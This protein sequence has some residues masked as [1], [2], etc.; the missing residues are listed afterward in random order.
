[1][2]EDIKKTQDIIKDIEV[3]DRRFR[4]ALTLLSLL[5]FLGV[6]L[7]LVLSYQQ[8]VNNQKLIATANQTLTNQSKVLS[9]LQ[10]V[11]RARTDQITELQQHIDC[12]V[13][14]FGA[15]N[16]SSLVISDIEQCK[17][18][19]SNSTS[20]IASSS[21]SSPSSSQPSASH[22]S[23]TPAPIA[24]SPQVSPIPSPQPIKP[25]T[26]TFKTGIPLIDDL[27]NQF[28]L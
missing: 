25:V 1:M 10:A 26:S 17:L 6:L 9:Q 22:P 18:S 7:L 2:S 8:S 24:K 13:A 15:P 5:L 16:R 12:I 28:N 19:N 14:L 27:L 3:K 21:L 20:T 23:V 4:I 11:S